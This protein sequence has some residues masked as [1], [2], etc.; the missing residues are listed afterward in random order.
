MGNEW[1]GRVCYEYMVTREM[2]GKRE[3]LG[4]AS[5]CNLSTMAYEKQHESNHEDE[6]AMGSTV[7]N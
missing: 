1:E 6:S 7:S 2:E 3:D 5:R 4:Y